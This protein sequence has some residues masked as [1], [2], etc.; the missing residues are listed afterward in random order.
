MLTGIEMGSLSWVHR[1]SAWCVSALWVVSVGTASSCSPAADPDPCRIDGY[2][3]DDKGEGA[4]L[5][6]FTDHPDS[7]RELELT[8]HES[9]DD[10]RFFF[11]VSDLGIDTNPDITVDL[12]S[13]KAEHLRMDLDFKCSDGPLAYIACNDEPQPIDGDEAHCEVEKDV[14]DRGALRLQVDYDCDGDPD[15][16]FATLA[17]SRPAP[18]EDCAAYRLRILV[19]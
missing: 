5:G 3:A 13:Y 12:T 8:F 16:G 15:D 17:L 9:G 11:R 1:A 7:A 18:A 2:E 10:D 14:G 19:E 4:D 6:T